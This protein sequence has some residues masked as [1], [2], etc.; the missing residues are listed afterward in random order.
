MEKKNLIILGIIIILII[1]A[2]VTRLSQ[3]TESP[4]AEPS[5][6]S[7]ALQL[8]PEAMRGEQTYN[9]TGS[10]DEMFRISQVIIDPLDVAMGGIQTVTVIVE[11]LDKTDIT[12]ENRV[13][14]TALT[15]NQTTEFS[16]EITGA[17]NQEQS[18][19]IVWQ[20]SWE[21]EDSYNQNYRLTVDAFKEG[22]EDSVTITF[23]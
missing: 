5:K 20:G 7:P 1:A 22:A 23:R 11:D 14:A 17:T 6:E 3:P 15:D 9:I 19:V 2:A 18:M 16:L 4:A 8:L 12:E 13:F 10:E 21:L